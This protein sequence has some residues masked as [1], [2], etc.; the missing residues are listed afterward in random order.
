[1]DIDQCL[2]KGKADCKGKLSLHK[3]IP[4]KLSTNFLYIYIILIIM[5]L[6]KK[7]FNS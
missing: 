4:K 6:L 5:K 7:Y 2:I 3:S 1:M